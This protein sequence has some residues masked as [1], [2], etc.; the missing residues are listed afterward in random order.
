MHVHNLAASKL[1]Q[2]LRFKS[3]YPFFKLYEDNV[4]DTYLRN[5]NV[6]IFILYCIYKQYYE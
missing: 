2:F 5:C 1:S 6:K 3:Q 4:I